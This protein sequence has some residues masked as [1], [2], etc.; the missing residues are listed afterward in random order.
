MLSRKE[1]NVS[2]WLVVSGGITGD[3]S[4]TGT[5]TCEVWRLGLERLVWARLP[6]LA[7]ARSD[8]ACCV[9]RGGTLVA[10]GGLVDTAHNGDPDDLQ[11]TAC[12][13]VQDTRA[14]GNAALSVELPQISCGSFS[15]ASALVA[16]AYTRPLLSSTSAVLVSEPR[17]VQFVTSC[18]QSVY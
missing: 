2:P 16:G 4:A 3:G 13:E 14:A 10:L 1:T 5:M 15:M 11:Q 8:H 18:D 7:R 17:C 12:V 6:D 9:V